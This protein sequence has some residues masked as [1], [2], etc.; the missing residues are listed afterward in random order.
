MVVENADYERFVTIICV[1]G[2]VT[3]A[4]VGCVHI[5]NAALWSIG[6]GIRVCVH[7]RC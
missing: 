6:M 4:V 3:L 1:L 7:T 2:N 5:A